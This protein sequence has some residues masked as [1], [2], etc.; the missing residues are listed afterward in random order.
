MKLY[1]L[2]YQ[3]NSESAKALAKSLNILRVD[4]SKRFN[5]TDVIINW[6]KSNVPAIQGNPKILNKPTA[7]AIAMN[8]LNTFNKLKESGLPIVDYTTSIEEASLWQDSGE[9]IFART[10]LTGS[11]GSGIVIASKQ[12]PLPLANLYTKYL[13]AH[14][15]RVH[16]VG[17]RVIDIQ[18][19]KRRINTEC[20]D[21]I[22]NAG[23][24]WV[25]CRENVTAPKEL[26]EASINAVRILGLDFGAID[27][28]YRQ[29]DNRVAILE[30]NTAPGIE[31]TTVEKYKEA[32]LC[33]YR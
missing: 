8:K 21:Y 3:M 26:Y 12:E 31:G 15:Y 17:S 11:K 22:K 20:N 6:G 16:V 30:V 25:F 2:P 23:G 27:I 19:K 18:K 1:I 28:L 32:L 13:K 5:T 24:G 7:I 10:N 33:A 14:E 4:G 9:T 29:V